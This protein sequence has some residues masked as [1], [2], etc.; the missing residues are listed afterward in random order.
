MTFGDQ[1]EEEAVRGEGGF[2]LGATFPLRAISLSLSC[3]L[4][5]VGVE[6]LLARW[7]GHQCLKVPSST[8]NAESLIVLQR[9]VSSTR[10]GKRKKEG[11][12]ELDSYGLFL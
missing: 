11:V 4:V 8:K 7:L 5:G 3:F 10:E 6:P 1:E 9:R 2:A 12:C